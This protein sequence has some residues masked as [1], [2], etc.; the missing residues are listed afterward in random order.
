MITKTL[1]AEIIAKA[2]EVAT[3]ELGIDKHKVPKTATT[4][5]QDFNSLKKK[6]D[7]VY[8]YLKVNFIFQQ[9]EHSLLLNRNYFQEIRSSA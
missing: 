7:V 5:E 3:K 8:T 6:P 9:L 1:D 2:T 4:F